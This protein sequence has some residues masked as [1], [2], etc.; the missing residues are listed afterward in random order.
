MERRNI[1]KTIYF[2]LLLILFFPAYSIGGHGIGKYD[3]LFLLIL[4]LIQPFL[5]LLWFIF[6][7]WPKKG[8][9][10]TILCRTL[11]DG[12]VVMYSGNH[13]S[14]SFHKLVTPHW[15][16][17][18]RHILLILPILFILYK[19]NRWTLSFSRGLRIFIHF[20]VCLSLVLFYAKAFDPHFAGPVTKWLI[21]PERL[22]EERGWEMTVESKGVS[23]ADYYGIERQLHDFYQ[24]KDGLGASRHLKGREDERKGIKDLSLQEGEDVSEYLILEEIGGYSVRT[25][26]KNV[27]TL[28]VETLPGYIIRKSPGILLKTDHFQLD[29]DDKTY[30][31]YY[32]D[33]NIG[34]YARVQVTLH[35][36]SNSDQ[37]LLHE[38]E[39]NFRKGKYGGMLTL[40]QLKTMDGQTIFYSKSKDREKTYCWLSNH[41]VV[42]MKFSVLSKYEQ[43]EERE[44]VELL[45][46]YLRKFPSTVPSIKLGQKYDKDWV[47]NEMDRRLWLCNSWMA[48]MHGGGEDFDWKF[49]NVI[50]QLYGFLDYR[51]FYYKNGVE[52]YLK[53]NFGVDEKKVLWGYYRQKDEAA[54]KNQ[55]EEYRRWWRHHR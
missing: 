39:S 48:W 41:M 21:D 23:W 16:H 19:S 10:I 30:E 20:F 35:A 6:H 15:F 43:E 49:K 37:W 1:L 34:S 31:A 28:Q 3:I 11:L 29:H 46:A 17:I 22:F 50:Y 36:G 5:I 27:L 8:G 47:K 42:H 24:F 12:A 38:V 25:K 26:R 7:I 52:R 40:D 18:D 4:V 33:S 2:T 32:E 14:W 13:Y 45:K 53:K 55:L 51:D 54:M 9:T 44:H